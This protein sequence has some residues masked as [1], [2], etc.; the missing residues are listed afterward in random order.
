MR[1]IFDEFEQIMY[2]YLINNILFFN[3]ILIMKEIV[4]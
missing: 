3:Y 1:Y 4:S 2:L